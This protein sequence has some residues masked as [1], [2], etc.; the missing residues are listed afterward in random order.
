[1][2][3]EQSSSV[4]A[5]NDMTPGTI[6][7]GLVRT[8][9]SSTSYVPPSRNNW[10][11]LF[12]PMF[13]E[14]LN[15]PS[16]VVNQAP[17]VIA[18]IA[19]EE[20]NE[21]ERL[22]VWELVPRPDQVMVIT[23]KWIYK[24]KLDKLGGILKN[25]ARL[26]AR[27]Y[28]QEEW[29]DFEESFALVARLE[30][31]RIFLSY[32]AHK[33]MVVYQMDVK[34][35]FLNG[36]L[37]EE[38][39]VSQPDGFVDPDNPNHVY[40]LKKPF[41]GLK[42]APRA[43]YD[44]LSSF[45]LSQDFSKVDTPM[46]SSFALTAFADADHA[47]CQDTR[48]STSGSVQ[49]LGERLI[50]WSSKRQKSV[51][52]SSTKAEYI[53]LSGCCAQILWMRSQLS[54]YGLGFNKI[55]M[56]CDNKSAIALCCNNVQHSR[57]KHIDIKYHFIKEQVENGV[58]ELYFVNTEY[59][60]AD[61]FTKA[62]GRDIIEFLTTKLGMRSFTL[63][64]LKQLMNE[65]DEYSLRTNLDGSSGTDLVSSLRTD[66]DGSSGTDLVSS[67]R[68]DLDGSSGTDL[69]ISLR[70]D[71]DDSF[72]TDL[73]SSLRT[74]LDGSLGTDLV[75]SQT[76]DLVRTLVLDKALVPSTKRLRIGRSNFTLPS[77]IQSK[78]STLQVVYD[79]LRGCPFFKAF[80]I[81]ADVPETYMQEFWAAAYVHQYFIRFKMDS[82]KNIVDLEAF[83]EMLHINPRVPGQ[84]FDE[85]PFEDE[86]LEFLQFL[87]HSA[88]IKTLTDVNVNKLFQH[89]RSFAAVINKCLTGKSSGFDSFRLSQAQILDDILFSTIKVVSRH[90][91]TQQYYAILP[92]ELMTEDI[93]NTKAYKEYYACA[94]GEAA[95]KPKVSARRKK[96]DSDTSI[97]H[98]TAIPTPITTVAAA[99]RLTAAAKGKQPAKAKSLSDPSEAAR[100]EAEQLKIRGGS[101]TDEGTGSKPGV[102]DVPS[103]DSEEEILW[104]SFDDE[105]ESFDPIP[106]TPE[107][108]EDD[109]NG[110]KDQGLRASEEQRLIE[111]EEADELYRD[112]DIN[113]GRGIQLSQDIKDSHVT[114]T[115]VHPDGQQES[116]SVSSFVT[117]MLNPI[118]DAGVESIFMTA[119]SSVAPLPTPIPIM[120]PSI[121]TTITTASHLPIPPTLIPS[122]V[123]QN[124][125]TFDSVFR[126]NKRLKSLEAS[127]S[128]Y[129]QTNPFAEAVS[130]ISGIVHQYMN[131]QMNEAVRVA[132]QIQN[133]RLHDSYQRE[134]DEFL[135]TIDDNMK[136]IIKEQE[137]P[138][139]GSDRGSK[140]RREG[141]EPE[142]ARAPL[143]PATRSACRSTG[144]K[145]R[146]ASVSESAFAEEPVQTISQIE[147][148]SYPVFETDAPI[149]FSNFIMNRLDVDTLTPE[150]LAG[151]TYE[152]M[153][154]SCNS[155]TELEYHLEEVYKVTTDQL[156]WVN[157]EGQQYPHNLL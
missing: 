148:P 72:G 30:A 37:R 123:I 20:L 113:Q 147:E 98:P 58:I 144:S 49:F 22:E 36:N 125:P 78:E 5:L 15:P 68:T 74:D 138:S 89:W 39:Y 131:Q 48:R 67:L 7:S 83:R 121:I 26:V 14:L 103:D 65:E 76:T 56:Y 41:Y 94:T 32:A 154:G 55:P 111:E 126:F 109:G 88:Q 9:S 116:S 155:L 47:G 81:T 24:V 108:S 25:K 99:P 1:M 115:L 69:V 107:D 149:D 35:A 127:F 128:E 50:S 130:N 2:A 86:I 152:L 101:S 61:L 93:R 19:E 17:E 44:M 8:S 145:S 31:I 57:S 29:I 114:L 135:K 40:K 45:L 110:E 34:T 100:T 153:R 87:R 97:T 92:I 91:N 43:W 54:D 137:G 59:Q 62:L 18:R 73:D 10:D 46:D 3:S 104:N 133:D 157:P 146:Q 120:T 21:F 102:L 66:L 11:S 136:R 82:K 28:R 13:D 156:D 4:P 53:A 60:L 63:E 79:V 84:S 96:S 42:Q 139:A 122:E 105:D 90:Q 95:P 27:G 140:R 38:V 106:R 77:D 85:L 33:N 119:S 12:Q 129:R 6:S 80:L 134:N 112:I 141:G 150:L 118:S 142:S 70:T 23:L 64:T 132:V 75:C 151:P 143:E 51:A 52:I 117:S 16:S 71:L 124:L